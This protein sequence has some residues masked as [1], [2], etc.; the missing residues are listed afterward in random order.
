MSACTSLFHTQPSS[1][2][3]KVLH[4]FPTRFQAPFLLWRVTLIILLSV[5]FSSASG[6]EELPADEPEE[7][8]AR[9][10]D[11]DHVHQGCFKHDWNSGLICL[12]LRLPP[13]CS[14]V[15][16]LVFRAAT[17]GNHRFFLCLVLGQLTAFLT[18][19]LPVQCMPQII[20]YLQVPLTVRFFCLP[21]R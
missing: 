2:L 13:A 20:P 11:P 8:E 19:F 7:G 12:P 18:R 21:A 3:K 4:R 5:D 16:P 17:T 6:V 15:I 14:V 9:G 10:F 1:T